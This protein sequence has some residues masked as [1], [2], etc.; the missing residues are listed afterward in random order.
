MGVAHPSVR[1][2]RRRRSDREHRRRARRSSGRASR[3]RAAARHQGRQRRPGRLAVRASRSATHPRRRRSPTASSA[4]RSP[5]TSCGFTTSRS[6]AARPAGS[7]GSRRSCAGSTRSTG[8]CS[9]SSSC[10]RRRPTARS[11]RSALGRSSTRAA[12]WPSWQAARRGA[13]LKLNLNLSARQFAEPALP[14][15][16]KRII[17]ETGLAPGAVWLEITETTLLAG[18][19]GQRADDGPAPRARRAP[20]DRRLRHRR[21]VAGVAQALPARRDQDRLDLRRRPR[22]RPRQRRDLQRDRGAGALARVVRRSP[23]GS[24]RSSSSR[25]CG[26]WSASSRR[27]TCSGRRGPREDYGAAPAATLGVVGTSDGNDRPR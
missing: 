26:H 20:G 4:M 21:L 18:P 13:T 11:C 3:E 7:P 1:A 14:A 6:S 5:A 27:V 15:Q 17:G 12:R 25:R 10:P 2:R 16:V 19:R 22:S 24:R 9:R 8:C 23:K